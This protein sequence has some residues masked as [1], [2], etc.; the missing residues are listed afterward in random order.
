[1]NGGGA[2]PLERASSFGEWTSDEDADDPPSRPGAAS[3][4][5]LAERLSESAARATGEDLAGSFRADETAAK[6]A[7]A[8]VVGKAYGHDVAEALTAFL[9]IP[10]PLGDET[11][12]A[13]K[14]AF[15]NLDGRLTGI[16]EVVGWDADVKGLQLHLLADEPQRVIP[17]LI[18]AL[19]ALDV[20]PPSKLVVTDPATGAILYERSL[21]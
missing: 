14:E 18:E 9:S 15:D 11:D 13:T 20:P 16:G 8:A 3:R 1:L 4:F 12:E 7:K 17:L 2:G 6:E 10:D 21:P 19:H 5:R